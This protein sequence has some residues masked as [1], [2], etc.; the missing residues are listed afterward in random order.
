PPGVDTE[1]PMPLSSQTNSTGVAFPIRCDHRAALTPVTAEAW[2][3]D[4]SPNDVTTIASS[5]TGSFR[6]RRRARPMA[7]ARPVAFG[8][9]EAIVE[10]WGGIQSS[11]LPHTLW[12]PPEA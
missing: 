5:A 12:R 2:L 8:T 10:V 1:I 9:C 11:R 4:A 7:T 3:A 6:P